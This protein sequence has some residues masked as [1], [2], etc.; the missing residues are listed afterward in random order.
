MYGLPHDF[1]ATALV[2][3]TLDVICFTANQVTFDFDGDFHIT[4]DGA[5]THGEESSEPSH[6]MRQVPVEESGLMRMAGA[7]IT[8]ASAIDGG[9]LRLL[10][11]RSTARRVVRQAASTN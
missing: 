5:F 7:S 11:S 2:G 8:D 9:T 10:F 6:L 4:V 3:R 1:D